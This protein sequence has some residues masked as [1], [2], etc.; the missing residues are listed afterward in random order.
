M[1]TKLTPAQESRIPEFRDK[2]IKVGLSTEPVNREEVTKALTDV[3]AAVGKPR[4]KF[5]IIL[6]SPH[7][8]C[9]AVAMLRLQPKV[10]AQ[11]RAQVSA[12]VRDQVRDQ[13]HAQVS[14][15]VSYIISWRWWY[16]FGQFEAYWN[17]FYEFFESI[18]IDISKLKPQLAY[19][20]A[21]GWSV[22]FWDWAIISDR[23]ESIH[24]DEQNRLHCTNAAAV[25]YR[26]GFSVWAIHGVRVN[27]KIVMSPETLTIEEIES[28]QNAEIRRVMIERFGQARFLLESG[29]KE[30]HHDDFGTLYRKEIPGDEPLVMVKVVNSTPEPDGSFKDYFLRVPPDKTTAHG[31]VAWTF[32]MESKDYAPLVET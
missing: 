20:R 4:P 25:R 27:E 17:S 32:G 9:L 22:L 3:Y 12:Q 14:A 18:G 5:V 19:T 11:V 24:R 10:S 2:W 1:I 8:V 13:V 23:P 6:P 28:E 7:Q 16:G 26:D 31:A 29:A 30:I 15:Q 21:A